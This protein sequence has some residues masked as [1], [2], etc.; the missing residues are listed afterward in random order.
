M[1]KKFLLGLEC[2]LLAYPTS[3]HARDENQ[4]PVPDSVI[5]AQNSALKASISGS[6]PG[7]QSPRDLSNREGRNRR[8]FA[9]APERQSL[10]ICNIH[11]HENA[12]HRGGE[13][14]TFAGNGD[15][16]GNGTGYKYNGKL[17]A[18]ELV[19]V[20]NPVGKGDEGD[21][22]PG[23]TVEIHFV[24][25]SADTKPGATLGACFNDA[26]KNPQLRVEAV[27]AVLVNGSTAM[28]MTEMAAVKQING[29]YQT[30]NLPDRLGPPVHYA[31]STT[32]PNY[33]EVA[34]PVQVT[35]SVRPSIAKLDINS[36]A[37]WLADNPFKENHAHGVRNLVTD[38]ELLSPIE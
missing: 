18:A 21:L 35:W 5:A 9:A 26:I 17:T 11:L 19:P 28:S 12:E 25:S 14:T 22:K 30:P 8:I 15:G 31:G 23:D 3:A 38:P 32:G 37:A 24:Y 13:F 29:L 10:N 6:G 16:H 36:L 34:S 7:P 33:N 2:L 20:L 4:S 1:V 27:V